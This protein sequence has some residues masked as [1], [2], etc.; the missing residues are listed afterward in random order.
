[1]KN[2]AETW[3]RC[4]A[5]RVECFE[6]FFSNDDGRMDRLMNGEYVKP[7]WRDRQA[8]EMETRQFPVK[9]HLPVRF[10]ESVLGRE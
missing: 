8:R 9:Y 3:K 2:D 4:V 6:M 7:I 10:G 5:L 1:M